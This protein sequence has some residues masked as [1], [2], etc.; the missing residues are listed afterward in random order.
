MRKKA[1]ANTLR[2]QIKRV[3][4]LSILLQTNLDKSVVETLPITEVCNIG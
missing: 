4:N 2:K 1:T 3:I